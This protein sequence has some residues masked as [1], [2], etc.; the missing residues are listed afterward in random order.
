MYK[1][2]VIKGQ[3]IIS[4]EYKITKKRKGHMQYKKT[5]KY[6]RVVDENLASRSREG[7]KKEDP[8][9]KPLIHAFAA[10]SDQLQQGHHAPD[11]RIWT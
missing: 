3:D 7:W 6:S 8:D 10:H 5:E 9:R 1:Y 4:Q 11:S 2:A